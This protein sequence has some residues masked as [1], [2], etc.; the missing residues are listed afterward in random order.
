NLLLLTTTP[1]GVSFDQVHL[2]GRLADDE[3]ALAR[4]RPDRSS[5]PE[6]DACI[7]EHLLRIQKSTRSGFR[8]GERIVGRTWRGEKE[9]RWD[10]NDLRDQAF[11]IRNGFSRWLHDS[12]LRAHDLEIDPAGGIT[13]GTITGGQRK[14]NDHACS[15]CL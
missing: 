8:I 2:I 13:V 7:L 14:R 4:I 1:L 6:L 15:P 5:R 9:S 10:P 3:D 11:R 12:H